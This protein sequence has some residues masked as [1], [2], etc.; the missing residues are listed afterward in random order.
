VR[1]A[2]KLRSDE[3]QSEQMQRMQKAAE[4]NKWRQKVLETNPDA[5]ISKYHA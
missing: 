3:S 5:T 2:V 1:K 4:D